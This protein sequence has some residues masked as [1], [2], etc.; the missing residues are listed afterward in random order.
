MS[1]RKSESI[2][3]TRILTGSPDRVFEASVNPSVLQQWPAPK[4]EVD[5]REGGHFRLEVPK[6]EGV[7]VVAGKYREFKQ[8]ECLV[9]TWVYDGPMGT[10]GDMEAAFR[11]ELRKHGSN[12]ELALQHDKLT[13]PAYRETIARGAWTTALDRLETLLAGSSRKAA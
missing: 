8:N 1:N 10:E 11:V 9:M 13:N 7:H 2:H 5:A 6:P 12:T 3:L 4:A